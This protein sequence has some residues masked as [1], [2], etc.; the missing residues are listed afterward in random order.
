MQGHLAGAGASLAGPWRGP[1]LMHQGEW[2]RCELR[3]LFPLEKQPHFECWL[4]AFKKLQIYPF[5]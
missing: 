5:S 1:A 4:Q 2:E 3:S